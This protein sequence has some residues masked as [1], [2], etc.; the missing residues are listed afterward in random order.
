[1]MKSLFDTNEEEDPLSE[2]D[3]ERFH[4]IVAKLLFI[5][6]RGRPDMKP[7]VASLST[8][9]SCATMETSKSYSDLYA[10]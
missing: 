8:R 3:A 9:V 4:L 1:M 7:M 10:T 2:S 6:K 5:S